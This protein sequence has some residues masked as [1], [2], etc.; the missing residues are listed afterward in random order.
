SRP[1]TEVETRD[2]GTPPSASPPSAPLPPQE[3]PKW[4]KL[5]LGAALFTF[6]VGASAAWVVTR[7]NALE[8]PPVQVGWP[9]T[10]DARVLA[11]DIEPLRRHLETQ[12]R[13]PVKFSFAGTYQ[14]LSQQ[15]LAGEVDFAT[16][17]PVLLV[18]TEDANPG[19]HPLATKIVGGNSR[20]DGV[21]VARGSSG[22]GSVADLKGK[23]LCIPD[24]DST[25]GVLFPRVAARRAG[26]DWD[27]DVR[28]VVSGNHLQVLRDLVEGRCEAGA[29][30]SAAL[31]NAVTQGVDVTGLR[32]VA[33]TGR[34]PQDSVVA[35]PKVP[36]PLSEQL[37]QALLSYHPPADR[38]GGTGSVERISGFVAVRP[39]DYAQVRELMA[40]PAP[41]VPD[42]A[43]SDAAP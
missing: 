1:P 37:R 31:L 7:A 24:R 8:G 28:L 14:E 40:P 6:S 43:E 10:I 25:T 42:A 16:L 4:T 22:M 41:P 13:R 29:T 3:R 20:S 32:Q 18:H 35:G 39:E 19:V 5:A 34:A 21:L 33:I 23:S 30:Y 2:M 15:L 38:P 36:A 27:R 17:P 12:V 9:P 11:E 26:V